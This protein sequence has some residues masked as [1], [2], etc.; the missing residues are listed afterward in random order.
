MAE[1]KKDAAAVALARLGGLK[2]GNA[3][4]KKLRLPLRHY[5]NHFLKTVFPPFALGNFEA[6]K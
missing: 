4:G 5:V 3:A 1:A 6:V 2:G